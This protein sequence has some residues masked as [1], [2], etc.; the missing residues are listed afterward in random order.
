MGWWWA[1]VVCAATWMAFSA[2][3]GLHGARRYARRTSGFT[4][5]GW[6][7]RRAWLACAARL[8][9]LRGPRGGLSGARPVSAARGWLAR[10]VGDLCGALVAWA[11]R[12]WS[13]RRV[14]GLRGVRVLCALRGGLRARAGGLRGA[15]TVCAARG[16]SGLGGREA[17]LRERG[18]TGPR[19]QALFTGIPRQ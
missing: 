16:C 13:R 8:P 15:R 2:R 3:C 5:R 14:C 1:R 4:A 10:G 17:L 18:T 9:S 12:V 7:T 6:C 19:I 11:A